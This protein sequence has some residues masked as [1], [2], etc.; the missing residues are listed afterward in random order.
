MTHRHGRKP[1][2]KKPRQKTVPK[3]TPPCDAPQPPAEAVP[4]APT[5]GP[6]APWA[7]SNEGKGYY[8]TSRVGPTGEMEWSF[9]SSSDSYSLDQPAYPAKYS[10]YGPVRAATT[11]FQFPNFSTSF[12]GRYPARAGPSQD[13]HSVSDSASDS[14]EQESSTAE[15]SSWSIPAIIDVD[16]KNNIQVRVPDPKTGAPK[17]IWDNKNKHSRQAKMS[18]GVRVREWLDEFEE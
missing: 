7:W 8:Y 12:M 9:A 13:K 6:W 5:A 10:Y 3:P 11:R 16:S 4:V 15:S 2:V 1:S 17:L 14:E 18:P